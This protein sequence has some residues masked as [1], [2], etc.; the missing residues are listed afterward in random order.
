MILGHLLRGAR[1]YELGA[2]HQRNRRVLVGQKL[3]DKFASSRRSRRSCRVF[4][5]LF[6]TAQTVG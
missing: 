3:F 5:R 6:G 2:A 1:H 4:R